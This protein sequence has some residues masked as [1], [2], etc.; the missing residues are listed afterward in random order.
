MRVSGRLLDGHG[1]PIAGAT[2]DVLQHLDGSASTS[3]IG[4]TRTRANGT[5]LANVAGG[6]TRTVQIA[7][8]AFSTDAG[9]A[10]VGT[11]AEAVDAGVKLTVTPRRTASEGTITLGGRVLGPIPRRAWLSSCSCTTAGRWEPFRAPRTDSRGRFQ[12]V[13]QFQGGIG[14]FPFRALVFGGQGGFP[15]TS[16]ESKAVDVTT[17]WIDLT[18]VQRVGAVLSLAALACILTLA[19][20]GEARRGDVDAALRRQPNGQPRRTM[21]GAQARRAM[22]GSTAA[23]RTPALQAGT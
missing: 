2:L 12:V 11:I 14:R 19:F 10:A 6:P 8:R 9:Y 16:G 23:T 22:S 1:H 20:A 3:V 7:Y 5:F 17:N 18:G 21:A 4:R 15:F 13:Y